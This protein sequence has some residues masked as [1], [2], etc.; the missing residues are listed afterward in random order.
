[1]EF[2]FSTMWPTEYLDITDPI[3]GNQAPT[4]ITNLESIETRRFKDWRFRNED[5]E[6]GLFG[7]EALIFE[8]L[9]SDVFKHVV[10]KRVVLAHQ[11]E[12]G[13]AFVDA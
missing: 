1:M 4:G 12:E 6:F 8:H 2:R 10:G 9:K 13:H 5:I 7:C 11:A 3:E